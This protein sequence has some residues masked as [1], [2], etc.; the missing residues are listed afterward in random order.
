MKK[1]TILL[2]VL[3]CAVMNRSW[4]EPN[5]QTRT[6][7][8]VISSGKEVARIVM[9]IGIKGEYH[10][11]ANKTENDQ[12][13][14]V[15]RAT[16]NAQI[17]FT[18][19]VATAAPRMDFIGDELILTKEVLD[20][21]KIKAITDL[22]AM[23]ESDQRYRG[24]QTMDAPSERLQTSIDVVNM[25][26]LADIIDRYGWPGAR[27]A[28]TKGSQN[29]FIVLQHADLE[30]QQ[31]YLPLLRDAVDR[32]DALANEL[33]MLEDRVRVGLGQP[34]IYGTQAKDGALAPIEDEANVDRRRAAVGLMPLADYTKLLF[35]RYPKKPIAPAQR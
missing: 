18:P 12:D 9:P 6:A 8:S 28:G 2:C 4:A 31:K 30:N 35:K 26:R 29:A 5:S 10:I 20:S 24:M 17:Y 23:G 22:E 25:V 3:F 16:G 11:L 7:I 19:A 13:G 34:Q 1:N 21:K 14:G 15:L 27:F 32:N 33:A